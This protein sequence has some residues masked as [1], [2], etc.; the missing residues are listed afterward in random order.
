MTTIIKH[1]YVL[2]IGM[3]I[4]GSFG[5]TN[6]NNDQDKMTLKVLTTEAE[7][8]TR[9][10]SVDYLADKIINKDPSLK[11]IDIRSEEQYLSFQINNAVNLP[12]GDL[13]SNIDDLLKD[14]EKYQLVFYGNADFNSEKAWLFLK[15]KGCS[16]V[17][18]LKGGLN[19]WFQDILNPVEPTDVAS[20]EEVEL[21]RSRVAM[22]NYFL[23]LSTELEKEPFVSSQPKKAIIVRP[24]K[25]VVEEEEG[26]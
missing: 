19:A 1:L 26:C 20:L 10:M 14:C 3:A 5:C 22:K 24:K 7:Q 15:S 13:E 25:V 11:I 16:N 23:G 21:Y 17:S 18:I 12:I 4:I 2:V 9:F 8:P 6:N